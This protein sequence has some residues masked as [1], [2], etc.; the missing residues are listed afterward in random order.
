MDSGRKPF[1]PRKRAGCEV[2]NEHKIN[3]YPF[4]IFRP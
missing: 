2:E 3:I 1:L 4:F